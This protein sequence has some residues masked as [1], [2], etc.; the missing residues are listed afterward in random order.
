MPAT[1]TKTSTAVPIEPRIPL[2]GRG[3]TETVEQRSHVIRIFA[4]QVEG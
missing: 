4:S 2:L 3:I 1:T